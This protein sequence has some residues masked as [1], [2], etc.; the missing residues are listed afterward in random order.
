MVRFTFFISFCA[1]SFLSFSKPFDKL[2]ELDELKSVLTDQDSELVENFDL[3]PDE[4]FQVLEDVLQSEYKGEELE[5]D[6]IKFVLHDSSTPPARSYRFEGNDSNFRR[7]NFALNNGKK[8]VISYHVSTKRLSY[9]TVLL[10]E[11]KKK[12]TEIRSYQIHRGSRDVASLVD[13]LG[14]PN[15]VELTY[16]SDHIYSGMVF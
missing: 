7:F 2:K 9:N 13:K 16:P 12:S 3:I 15:I 10:I 8:W 5:S 4:I 14:D 6:D 1:L 11:M